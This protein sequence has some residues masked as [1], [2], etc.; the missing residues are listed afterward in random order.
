MEVHAPHHPLNNWKDFFIHLATITVGLL[1]AL[2][3]EAGAEA[4]HHHHLVVEARENIRREIEGEPEGGDEQRR[5]CA[6]GLGAH[7]D[8]HARG[9]RAATEPACPRPCAYVVPVQL[10]VVQRFGVAVGAGYGR[11]ELHAGR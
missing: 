2:A 1:I 11:F 5:V 3:L 9:G 10:V 8:E 4:V 6:A 7:G